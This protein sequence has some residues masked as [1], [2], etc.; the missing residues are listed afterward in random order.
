[1]KVCIIGSSG[2]FG[3]ALN[4]MKRDSDLN[5]VGIAPG[6][7]GESVHNIERAIDSLDMRPN[8]YEDFRTMLEREK[9]DIAVVNPYF[10]DT[11]RITREVIGRG[12]H[13]FV[14]KP[15]ATELEELYRLREVYSSSDVHL[16]AMFGIRYTS[17]FKTAWS[18]V[19][20]GKIGKVRII[21]AQKSYKLGER[22]ELYK[23]RETYGG[24]IPWVGS[25]AIDW[26]YWFSQEEFESVY[27]THSGL[28]N[29]NHGDLEVSA[30]CQFRLSNEV[31]GSVNIDYLRPQN[32]PTHDDDRLRIAGTEGIVEVYMGKVSLING[33]TEGIQE[34]DLL[35]EGQIFNDFVTQIQ[36]QGSCIVSAEDSFKVTEACLKAR[37]SADTGK[38]VKI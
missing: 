12:I 11:C 32:A 1:M 34:V 30:L 14:E 23:R 33:E 15:L 4:G 8:K 18:I 19:N 37:Q 13:A 20:E 21:T 9:P 17:H 6:S 38:I 24:T 16:A 27:A 7:E 26:V 10:F 35:P 2:H 25:H 3:Y 5:L 29:Q 22:S 28:Y 31:M 36:G